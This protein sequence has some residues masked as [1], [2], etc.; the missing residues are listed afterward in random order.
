MSFKAKAV[1][2]LFQN[3]KSLDE[4]QRLKK[5]Y[6]QKPTNWINLSLSNNEV[7]FPL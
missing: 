4:Y 5:N 3:Y 2:Q 1:E 7:S 6:S